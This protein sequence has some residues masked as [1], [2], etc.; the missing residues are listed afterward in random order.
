MKIT[1]LVVPVAGLGTK[2]L[3]VTKAV[4]KAMM[5]ILDKPVIHYIL[6][7][8]LMSG[9]K[10]VCIILN[11][12]QDMIREYLSHNSKLEAELRA[13]GKAHLVQSVNRL[14]D[15]LDITYI[16]QE[17]PKGSGHAIMLAKDFVG[18]DSFMVMYGDSFFLGTH[19][20]FLDMERAYI[21]YDAHIIGA[22]EV[23][24][25]DVNKYGMLIMDE[26][27]EDRILGVV[28]KPS[29]RETPSL[30]ACNGVYLFKPSV[31]KELEKIYKEHKECLL[32]DMLYRMMK[33]EEF[34]L[35]KTDCFF[36]DI[37]HMHGYVKATNDAYKVLK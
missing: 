20:V 32:T 16:Y 5:P 15:Q 29:V 10:E 19:S 26:E 17:E 34:Y 24:Y 30:L 2:F 21:E 31:F 25:Q 14:I 23:E 11:H 8:A 22:S 13:S 35:G 4:P 7:N 27:E 33:K 28:E 12:N 37:G 1:K 3:P 36:Y 6:E 9:I 18:N